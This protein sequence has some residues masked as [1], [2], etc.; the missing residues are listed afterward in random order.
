MSSANTRLRRRK[1]S[2]K[3]SPLAVRSSKPLTAIR[4][5][6]NYVNGNDTIST[7]YWAETVGLIHL[8][9]IHYPKLEVLWLGCGGQVK[10]DNHY[11]EYYLV[12]ITNPDVTGMQPC[13]VDLFDIGIQ[14]VI[15]IA[16]PA[17]LGK[18]QYK[19]TRAGA[20]T[21]EISKL[22]GSKDMKIGEGR[23]PKNL[24]TFSG[25]KTIYGTR[26]DPTINDKTLDPYTLTFSGPQ[27]L[28]KVYVSNKIVGP[29]QFPPPAFSGG[30]PLVP[31]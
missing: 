19:K 6:L 16:P 7:V 3:K 17:S 27:C 22:S 5:I 14:H 8:A 4:R 25:S 26:Y 23:D 13:S 12:E 29:R 31:R 24:K 2:Q 10:G 9:G 18:K 20:G 30:R 1:A 11:Y 21:V 15:D 28:I